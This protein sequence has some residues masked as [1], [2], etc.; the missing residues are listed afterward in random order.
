M[1]G[2]QFFPHLAQRVLDLAGLIQNLHAAGKG[3][4]ANCKGPLDGRGV[5]P[6]E[7]EGSMTVN[8][9]VDTDG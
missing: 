9:C 1:K 4:V 2:L 5:S 7:S 3:V 6:G 8:R